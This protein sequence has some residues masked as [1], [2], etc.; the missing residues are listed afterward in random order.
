M[1]RTYALVWNPSLAT[2]SV[3]D[4]HARQRGK[5]AGSILAAALLLP[6][7][8]IAADLPSGGN[9]VA[10]SGQ[11]KTPSANQMVIDQT[12]NKLAIDWQSFDIAAG[13]KVTFN[14]HGSDSIALNRV[15]GA[16]GSK[17][18]GQ[19]DANGRVFLINPNG[20]LFGAGAQ[21]NVGGL[22]ASTLNLSDSD[23]AAGNYKFK[24]SGSNASVIN[25]GHI[26][27]A[28]GGSIALLGGTV[29]N[30]G[31]IVANQGTVA[32]AAGNAVTLDFAG[33][34]LLNVQV[35]EAVVDALVE[36]H[37]LIKADGGQ[38]LLTANA[39]DALLKTVVNN[40]GVIEAHTLGEKNGKIALLG[41]FAGG[42][43]QVAG[44]LD[45]G[46][47]N[48][49]N[50]G[51]IETS[52]AHVKVA[53]GTK[54]TTKA[55]KG[56]T[57]T[58][59]I[60][61]T[62]FTISAGSASKTNSGIGADT[63]SSNLATNNMILQT[64][65]TGNEAGNINVN[66]AVTWNAGTMLTLS[67]HNSININAAITAQHLS[68]KVALKYGQATAAGGTSDYHIKAPINL[69]SGENF[70][71]QKGSTGAVINYTVV[72]DATALQ[73]MNKN[74]AGN[75]A[76]GSN[77]DLESISSWNSVGGG[78]DK[79]SERFA[80]RFDGLGHT[81]RKLT[82]NLDKANFVGL[83]GSTSNGSVIR[84]IGLVGVDVKG[85]YWVGGLVGL[86]RGTISNADATGSV[87]GE[88]G[89]GGLVGLQEEGSI[90]NAYATGNVKGQREVG[91]L[92]GHQ[93]NKGLLNTA[94][95]S[96]SVTG[97]LGEVG[98]LVGYSQGS[99]SNAYVEPSVDGIVNGNTQVGG[100]VGL[101]TGSISN[102][103]ANVN[104]NGNTQVG[105]L[106]GL[107][108]GKIIDSYALGGVKKNTNGDYTG[109]GGLVGSN[110]GT[111]SNV[112]ATGNVDG[113]TQVGGLVGLNTGS[114]SNAYASGSVKGVLV[115]GGLVGLQEIGSISNAYA[116]GSVKGF[117]YVGGLVGYNYN[118]G[119]ISNAYATGSVE[120]NRQVG[121]LIGENENGTISNSFYATTAANKDE[122]NNGGK[123]TGVF[124]GNT[125]GT[126]KT[127]AELTQTS[128]FTGWSIASTG[129]SGAVWRIYDGYSGPLLRSFLKSVTLNADASGGSKI[130][131]GT[132]ATGTTTSYTSSLGGN[133][134]TSK[135]LGNLHYKSNSEN[136]GTYRYA[137]G[138]LLLSGLYSD[139]QG[140]DINYADASLTISKANVTLSGTKIYD[141]ATSVA[142][143]TL[144][145]AGVGGQ[146]FTVTGVGDASNLTSKNVQKGAALAS[147]TGL[148]LGSSSNGG[149]ARN[150]NLS[151]A[152]SSYTVTPK[153]LTLTGISALDKTYDA[154]TSAILNTPNVAYS[155]QVDGDKVT[156]AGNGTGSFANK[157]AGANKSVAVSGYSLV[158]GDAGN[159][160][161]TQPSGLTASI[162]KAGLTITANDTSKVAGQSI[163]L[164]GYRASGLV[165]NDSI[166]AVSLYSL[167]QPTT[168]AAGSY[169]IVVSNAIGAAL[170]N[171]GIRYQNG[172]LLVRAAASEPTMAS[173]PPYIGVLVSNGQTVLT[174]A[175]QQASEPEVKDPQTLMTNPLAEVTSLQVINQGIRLPEGI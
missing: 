53:D 123:T 15:L 114:I 71:T 152:G 36:N 95:A 21:V 161:L 99:I 76:V 88:V 37:Q 100:L 175:P 35:D 5:G 48:G 84:D 62:D 4:E 33:D 18:M 131:D 109:L 149:L 136:A 108:Y 162:R 169:S 20:V 112:F 74:L 139:Q 160:V 83:F 55:A 10:G 57:G 170:S 158:G 60:D 51:F 2:W 82:I 23:F 7:T 73:D 148:S 120:G 91:G 156:L 75:Y 159:Y 19:L 151:T 9:V 58:W 11:I 167:G 43:V 105:G 116:T 153:G 147:T 124:S 145:A 133:L 77:I 3:T 138:S 111:I 110:K 12:S 94:Y 49:G 146:T 24:G 173:T 32:L 154:S 104:V 142:G 98:G 70:N 134:D 164:N 25:N 117:N 143:S 155:G 34:G 14:Q 89:V 92:V 126:G 165:G 50:G 41:S 85:R 119:A 72:N 135:I 106:V 52:G 63:L 132:A 141:G 130:Y 8:A 61:P 79:A 168:A 16:D 128:T 125:H 115:V 45:A 118:G 121:G 101:N 17:I 81:L 122:I 68:G 80:G 97:S 166:S 26:T 40:T 27:A 67:A 47:P 103:Y 172:T 107:N 30:N 31:V 140:Y 96:G 65:A 150:Y 137:D 64:A 6:L 39:G 129:G 86:S 59:L 44:T 69:Q 22:V 90:S 174:K 78:D 29:S 28:D 13:H 157:N 46:A 66:A 54:V 42:T 102:A 127:W 93:Y 144:T 87:E 171:Y 56:K 1:N 38:V 113:N 163:A